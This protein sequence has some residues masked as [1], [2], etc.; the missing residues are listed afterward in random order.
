MGGVGWELGS[1]LIDLACDQSTV[2][3]NRY[4]NIF[5]CL[6]ISSD[7]LYILANSNYPSKCSSNTE[8]QEPEALMLQKMYDGAHYPPSTPDTADS[9]CND[10]KNPFFYPSNP[11][12]L[13]EIRKYEAEFKSRD[14]EAKEMTSDFKSF[15]KEYEVADD[16]NKIRPGTE[17]NTGPG[18]CK[19][20][21]IS[22]FDKEN[23]SS[24][25]GNV[26]KQPSEEKREIESVGPAVDTT[27]SL[28]HEKMQQEC[29]SQ[30]TFSQEVT[31][32]DVKQVCVVQA[33]NAEENE[34][35]KQTRDD[36]LAKYEELIQQGGG[37]EDYDYEGDEF[38][39]E[40]SF[41]NS[42]FDTVR[43]QNDGMCDTEGCE[44]Q[45]AGITGTV[46]EV[47]DKTSKFYFTSNTSGDQT[48]TDNQFSLDNVAE[49]RIEQSDNNLDNSEQLNLCM[50]QMTVNECPT[51]AEGEESDSDCQPSE[52]DNICNDC[53]PTEGNK[54]SN[55]ND[56]RPAEGEDSSELYS[57]QPYKYGIHG[58][59]NNLHPLEGDCASGL[60]SGHS[61][62][63]VGSDV[64]MVSNIGRDKIFGGPS[65][66]TLPNTWKYKKAEP[67][68]NIEQYV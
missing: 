41:F 11:D 5:V 22:K 10:F 17:G 46:K 59:T 43:F 29:D 50:N 45:D 68:E 3:T 6:V 31:G 33:A 39:D 57:Q 52:G 38:G 28:S 62:Q 23:T 56:F 60:E 66:K 54:A 48:Q 40:F 36:F 14:K 67:S 24:G 21:E 37:M 44:T 63:V 64:N 55:D 51:P 58:S 26:L 12:K 49:N 1:K 35:L 9:T 7:L 20:E 4:V 30:A 42:D 16:G 2:I 8:S 19:K 32:D 25:K 13:E 15:K 61:S 53:L 65:Y 18:Q 47:S 27:G 34:K